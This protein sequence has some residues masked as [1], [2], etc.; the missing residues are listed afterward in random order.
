MTSGNCSPIKNMDRSCRPAHD[1][2]QEP[3]Y[4]PA[5]LPICSV[6]R[7]CLLAYRARPRISRE[8]FALAQADSVQPSWRP[9][10]LLGALSLSLL[11]FVRTAICFLKWKVIPI[12]RALL[13]FTERLDYKPRAA[14]MQ[15]V[16]KCRVGSMLLKN[17]I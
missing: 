8:S 17:R 9:S 6:L 4:L 5:R 3:R 16:G 1:G 13:A 10:W 2:R 7:R 14:R 15:G 11:A 12:F